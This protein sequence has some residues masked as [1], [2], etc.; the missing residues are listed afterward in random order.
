MIRDAFSLLDMNAIS[1]SPLY[2]ITCII[3]CKY[4]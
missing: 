3:N 4:K 2:F 1:L